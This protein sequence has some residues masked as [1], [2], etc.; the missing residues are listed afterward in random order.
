MD[1]VAFSLQYAR[2][3]SDLPILDHHALYLK[4]K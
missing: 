3:S 1:H 2:F 4:Q